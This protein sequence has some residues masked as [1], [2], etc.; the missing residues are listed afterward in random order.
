M[1]NIDGTLALHLLQIKEWFLKDDN[2]ESEENSEI[3]FLNL[4]PPAPAIEKTRSLV[5]E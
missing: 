3:I 4:L 2:F 5:K 1:T